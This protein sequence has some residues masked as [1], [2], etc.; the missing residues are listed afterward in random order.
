[1]KTLSV[2]GAIERAHPNDIQTIAAPSAAVFPMMDV[3]NE[4]DE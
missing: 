1:L 4:R 3:E 2:S